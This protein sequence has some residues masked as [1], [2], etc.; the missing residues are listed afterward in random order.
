MLR[1]SKSEL[2]LLETYLDETTKE[3]KKPLLSRGIRDIVLHHL[4]RW[5]NKDM[6]RQK[7]RARFFRKESLKTKLQR[8]SIDFGSDK[9]RVQGF[10]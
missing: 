10:K 4:N 7:I 3:G 2:K 5:V 9:V 6:K 1:L 8:S